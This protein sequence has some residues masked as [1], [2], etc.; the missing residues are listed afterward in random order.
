MQIT[1][2]GEACF[3][4]DLSAPLASTLSHERVKLDYLRTAFAGIAGY[5]FFQAGRRGLAMRGLGC[6]PCYWAT[7]KKLRLCYSGP[8][9]RLR[10]GGE[11]HRKRRLGARGQ[12][13][14]AGGAV[15]SKI[16][17]VEAVF[18]AVL[19]HSRNKSGESPVSRG[20]VG[21]QPPCYQLGCLCRCLLF[22]ARCFAV[23]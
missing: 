7:L 9:P 5:S 2:Q 3:H 22:A 4:T 1:G 14:G 6:S 23:L 16:E 8:R 10:P 18:A 11:S 20:D 15:N 13:R 19:V 12:G 21:L 17:T